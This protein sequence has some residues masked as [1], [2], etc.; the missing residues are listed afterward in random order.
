MKALMWIIA[1]IGAIFGIP[2]LWKQFETQATVTTV[3]Q[4]QTKTTPQ[5]DATATNATLAVL[6]TN[7]AF[8]SSWGA[9][10][11]LNPKNPVWPATQDVANTMLGTTTPVFKASPL[12]VAGLN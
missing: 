11:S 1:I 9:Q 2:L 5:G 6:P 8:A 12:S 4:G 7:A 10:I 3:Y